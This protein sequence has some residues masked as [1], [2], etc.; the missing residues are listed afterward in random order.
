MRY[1]ANSNGEAQVVHIHWK[2]FRRSW[3]RG[4]RALISSPHSWIFTSVSVSCR[5]HAN[6]FKKKNRGKQILTSLSP[7]GK[8]QFAVSYFSTSCYWTDPG[9]QLGDPGTTHWFVSVDLM[10][11]FYI[12]WYQLIYLR[13]GPNRCLHYTKVWHKTC[14]MCNVPFSRSA[15]GSFAQ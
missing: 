7:W 8:D 11:I 13:Y 3:P 1:S 9:L 10:L 2:L 4:F 12:Y 14:L 5:L 6:L 15:R